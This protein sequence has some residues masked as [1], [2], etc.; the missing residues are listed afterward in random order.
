MKTARLWPRDDVMMESM[1]IV[2]LLTDGF[3]GFGGIS[4]FNRDLMQALD[5]SR[6]TERVYTFPRLI[7]EPIEEPI[8]ESAVYDRKAAR[9]KFAFLRRVL[10]Y[11]WRGWK[12]DIVIC[13]HL[14]LLPAAWLIARLRG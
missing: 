14:N 13:G 6:V 10:W 12:P 4:K 1:N 2:M 8:P 9:G 11:A 3:G 7:P 5:A